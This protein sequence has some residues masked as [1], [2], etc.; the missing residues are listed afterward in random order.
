MGLSMRGFPAWSMGISRPPRSLSSRVGNV[1]TW[2]KQTYKCEA[3]GLF[4]TLS[5][6]RRFKLSALRDASLLDQF[7]GGGQ[8][9]F[10]DGQAERFGGLE[11][12]HQIELG[13]LLDREIGGFH[14]IKN[15]RHIGASEALE[16]G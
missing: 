7:I 2:R 5:G 16:Q 4:L 12:D 15:P 1:R 13:R 8:Q 10:G 3:A 9:R 14:A 11:V 6:C